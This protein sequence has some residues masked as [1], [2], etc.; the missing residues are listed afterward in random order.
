M[1][2]HQTGLDSVMSPWRFK[3]RLVWCRHHACCHSREDTVQRV[4]LCSNNMYFAKYQYI[5]IYLAESI[6]HSSWM[7]ITYHNVFH[8]QFYTKNYKLHILNMALLPFF[9]KVLN[10]RRYDQEWT[11]KTTN[12]TFENLQFRYRNIHYCLSLSSVN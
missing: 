10:K 11:C 7:K 1:R 12:T 8:M 6:F 5:A 2:V 9:F 4:S 3:D